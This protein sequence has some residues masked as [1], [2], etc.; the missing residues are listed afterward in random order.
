MAVDATPHPAEGSETRLPDI[1]YVDPAEVQQQLHGSFDE[2]AM[3]KS[4][5]VA[6]RLYHADRPRVPSPPKPTVR[7]PTGK[8][9]GPNLPPGGWHGAGPQTGDQM[10]FNP[11]K[12]LGEPSPPARKVAS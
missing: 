6:Q 3:K 5:Q 10:Q 1:R 7:G 2:V 12:P 8:K 4:P 11:E 9:L